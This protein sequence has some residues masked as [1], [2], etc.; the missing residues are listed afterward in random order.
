MKLSTKNIDKTI[1]TFKRMNAGERV[2]IWKTC[3][4][5]GKKI[6]NKK[7]I[8]TVINPY[9]FWHHYHPKCLLKTP[10]N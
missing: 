3:R 6:R 10:T 4:V 5:C 8:L 1:R 9:G 2:T 7:K